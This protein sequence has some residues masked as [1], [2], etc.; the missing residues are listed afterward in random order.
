MVLVLCDDK[1]SPVVLTLSPAI[2]ENVEAELAVN[3]MFNALPLHIVEV[4]ALVIVGPATGVKVY[5]AVAL[6]P[7]GFIVSV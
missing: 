3:G 2:H 6:H 7:P 4:L 5:V 1:L